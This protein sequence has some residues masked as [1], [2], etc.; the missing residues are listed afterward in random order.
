[1]RT[2]RL[3][4][5]GALSAALILPTAVAAHAPASAFTATINVKKAYANTLKV[6]LSLGKTDV[7]AGKSVN[8]YLVSETGSPDPDKGDGRWRTMPTAITLGD[9]DGE[10][11]VHAW[12][13]ATGGVV[14][15]R[16]S[17]TV[18][19]DR[20]KPQTSDIVTV[21]A[22]A[23]APDDPQADRPTITSRN[24]SISF[25][26]ND[27]GESADPATGSG[28]SRYAVV[29]G[30]GAPTSGS[31]AWTSVPNATGPVTV[32][33]W[34][35]TGGNGNK[36][37][38]LFVRDR[39]GNVSLVSSVYFRLQLAGPTVTL[40]IK[41]YVR[42]TKPAVSV[43]GT[44]GSNT[45]VAGFYLQATATSV[46]PDAPAASANGWRVK[47]TKVT[48]SGPGTWYVWA[49][50][51]DDN[52]SVSASPAMETVVVDTTAPDVTFEFDEV[53]DGGGVDTTADRSV[54]WTHSLDAGTGAPITHWVLKNGTAAPTDVEWK[55]VA[56]AL[57]DPWV[58]TVGSG[59]KTVTLWAKDGAGN[60]GSDADVVVVTLPAPTMT[61]NMPAYS[62]ALKVTGIK[63]TVVDTAGSGIAGYFFNESGTAPTASANG[64]HISANSFTF[65]AGDGVRTL[66]AWVKDKNG[67]VSAAAATDTVTID[68]VKPTAVLSVAGTDF[69]LG[70]SDGSGTGITHYALVRT[71][72]GAPIPT[73]PASSAW[74]SSAAA[75]EGS[76]TLQSG[77]NQVTLYT[78]DAAGNISVVDQQMPDVSTLVVTLP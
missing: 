51:K 72:V 1:M 44:A 75:A 10:H 38:S 12:A 67:T 48:L 33:N 77:G 64:W 69:T 43:K 73:S 60:V 15:A 45:S 11:T 68:T 19:V 76:I 24:V 53:E 40:T 39:A 4:S 20:V 23:E 49:W 6:D 5:I 54:A 28:V 50:A 29:N 59:S 25:K 2:A 17:D 65:S 78:R 62:T 18:F 42:S 7:P 13:R 57:A 74:K 26:Y 46:A 31:S 36:T 55:P 35:V 3:F 34:K 56:T 41:D 30:V 71:A 47:P 37:V 16:G 8:A 21:P 63:T 58:L 61:V 27:P 22:Q 52:G 14:S 66:Y 70:G 9:A 32:S